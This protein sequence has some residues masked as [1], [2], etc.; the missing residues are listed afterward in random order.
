[1]KEKKSRFLIYDWRK[2]S[3]KLRKTKPEENNPFEIVLQVD[4]EFELPEIG[5]KDFSA[6][7]KVS[8]MF[9]EI[10]QEEGDSR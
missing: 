9:S 7:A 10:V 8:R 4:L 2:D 1:M 5:L 3:M 6:D